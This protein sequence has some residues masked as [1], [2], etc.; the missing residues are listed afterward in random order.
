MYRIKSTC[1]GL[2]SSQTD[3]M[4]GNNLGDNAFNIV[5]RRSGFDCPLGIQ[6]TKSPEISYISTLLSLFHI[7]TFAFNLIYTS[8]IYIWGLK[9]ISRGPRAARQHCLCGPR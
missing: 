2:F 4:I 8:L 3:W 9:Q 1:P 5:T 6:V 7:I